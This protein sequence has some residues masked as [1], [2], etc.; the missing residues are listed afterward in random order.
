MTKMNSVLVE[1]SA[2]QSTLDKS[3]S[4]RQNQHKTITII[5]SKIEE[6]INT[7]MVSGIGKE[8]STRIPLTSPVGTGETIKRLIV[9]NE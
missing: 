5:Q 1:R 4:A 7:K 2:T 3:L 8:M 9:R 6:I